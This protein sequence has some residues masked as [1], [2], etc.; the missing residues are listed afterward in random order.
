MLGLV[1]IEERRLARFR[2]DTN[3]VCIVSREWTAWLRLARRSQRPGGGCKS[4]TG[5]EYSCFLPC[6]FRGSETAKGL[7]R[8]RD[9]GQRQSLSDT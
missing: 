4:V 5:H 8:N 6:E 1:T 7:P 3:V 2:N 9:Q